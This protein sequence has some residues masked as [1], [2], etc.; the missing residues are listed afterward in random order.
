MSQSN[1]DKMECAMERLKAFGKLEK[2]KAV[3]RVLDTQRF[4]LKCLANQ[5][6]RKIINCKI[7][8]NEI[9]RSYKKELDPTEHILLSSVATRDKELEILFQAAASIGLKIAKDN[10]KNVTC[11]KMIK[12]ILTNLANYRSDELYIHLL[13][14]LNKEKENIENKP[15]VIYIIL[16]DFI[17]KN[18]QDICALFIENDLKERF[19]EDTDNLLETTNGLDLINKLITINNADASEKRN[20]KDREK[21]E[22]LKIDNLVNDSIG[23]YIEENNNEMDCTSN[24]FKDIECSSEEDEEEKEKEEEE[25]EEEEEVDDGENNYFENN[26]NNDAE[27]EKKLEEHKRY[28]EEEKG[29]EQNTQKNEIRVETA[30]EDEISLEKTL[31]ISNDITKNVNLEDNLSINTLKKNLNEILEVNGNVTLFQDENN[32]VNS[33]SFS[34]CDV[35]ESDLLLEKEIKK[36]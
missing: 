1:D 26:D 13:E 3:P 32:I 12:N 25:E 28:E 5:Q 15:D 21:T 10:V 20:D 31:R 11:L 8:P 7:I 30:R 18:I 27:E 2:K 33:T 4:Y 29:F 16:Y 14:D 22:N 9:I 35:E 17:S 24:V 19:I 36:N 6:F 34:E 23:V